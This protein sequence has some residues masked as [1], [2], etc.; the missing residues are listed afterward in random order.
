MDILTS[1]PVA[2][3]LEQAMILIES[4]KPVAVVVDYEAITK[5]AIH[6]VKEERKRILEDPRTLVTQSEAHNM[7][8]KSVITSLVKSGHLQ[9]YKFGKRE[10]YDS[11]GDL[12]I[13]T[14]GVVYYRIVEI[15]EAV[16]SG[17]VLK[18][19]RRG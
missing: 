1:N 19:T 6:A 3:L 18:G 9:Q 2:R 10:V 15:E 5:A 11:E 12:I 4:S 16:E 17:N 7:Y 8:G 14:K 13:K